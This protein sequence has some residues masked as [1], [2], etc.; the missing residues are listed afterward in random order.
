MHLEPRGQ[1]AVFR[2]SSKPLLM[3]RAAPTESRPIVKSEFCQ[4]PPNRLQLT[5]SILLMWSICLSLIG[6]SVGAHREYDLRINWGQCFI[7]ASCLI[8]DR[9]AQPLAITYFGIVSDYACVQLEGEML[10]C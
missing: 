3:E 7:R 8:V 6:Q 4:I 1:R 9:P 2:Q 10:P 5:D